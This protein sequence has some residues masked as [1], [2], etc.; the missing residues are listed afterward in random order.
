MPLSGF[1]RASSGQARIRD[2]IGRLVRNCEFLAALSLY[3]LLRH[4]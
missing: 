4:T 2:E 3:D 1:S